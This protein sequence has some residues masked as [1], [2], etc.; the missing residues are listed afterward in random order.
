MGSNTVPEYPAEYPEFN[1]EPSLE[2]FF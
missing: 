2:P 1:A